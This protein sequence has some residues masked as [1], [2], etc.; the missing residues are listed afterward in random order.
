MMHLVDRWRSWRGVFKLFLLVS[1]GVVVGCGGDQASQESKE[2]LTVRSFLVG[3]RERI[4]DALMS[5]EEVFQDSVAS[6]MAL[7]GFDYFPS[8]VAAQQAAIQ[9]YR[10]RRPSGLVGAVPAVEEARRSGFGI[11][12]ELEGRVGASS[13]LGPRPSRNEL[14]QDSLGEAERQEY[15][16]TLAECERAAESESG[17]DEIYRMTDEAHEL[18]IEIGERLLADREFI[19]LNDEWSRCYRQSS[20]VS[21]YDVTLPF[22]AIDMLYFEL[23]QLDFS[24]LSDESAITADEGWLAFK[25]REREVALAVSQCVESVG[26]A[27]RFRAIQLEVVDEV[28]EG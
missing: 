18:S 4:D 6:C 27:E 16:A 17:V 12:D 26:Y 25:A 15:F 21:D 3:D 22:E 28:L 7:E 13:S 14:I 24:D 19:S 9:Q 8:D 2:P 23:E 11:A 1:L 10:S 20:I 5:S